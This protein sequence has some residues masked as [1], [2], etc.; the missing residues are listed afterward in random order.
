MPET[1]NYHLHLVDVAEFDGFFV[2][3]RSAWLNNGGYSLVVRDFDT[4][5][6]RKEG[7][8]SHHGPFEFEL[9]RFCLFDGLFQRVYP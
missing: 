5:G 9:E 8:G 4:V 7:I 6:E 2:T 3:D 1:G